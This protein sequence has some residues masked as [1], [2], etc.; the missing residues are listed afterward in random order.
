MPSSSFVH[1][2]AGVCRYV[3][4][5]DSSQCVYVLV[6]VRMRMYY[7]H[8]YGHVYFFVVHSMYS[9]C[10]IFSLKVRGSNPLESYSFLFWGMYRFRWEMTRHMAWKLKRVEVRERE[11]EK[12]KGGIGGG[13]LRKVQLRLSIFAS[14]IHGRPGIPKKVKRCWTDQGFVGI[15]SHLTVECWLIGQIRYFWRHEPFNIGYRDQ[16]V[17]HQLGLIWQLSSGKSKSERL[18][19]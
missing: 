9:L 14:Y 10:L 12:G 15:W 5:H 3:Q 13:R 8:V 19:G 11:L 4:V 16:Q 2:P 17:W 1:I 7:Q 6:R 18:R